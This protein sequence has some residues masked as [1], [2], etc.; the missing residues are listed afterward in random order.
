M[1]RSRARVFDMA[2]NDDDITAIGDLFE[3]TLNRRATIDKVTHRRHHDYIDGLIVA[4]ET[5]H[6]RKEAII[7]QVLGWSIVAA[8][9]AAVAAVAKYITF[10]PPGPGQ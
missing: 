3:T 1:A 10:G 4:G 2:L 7:R 5:R 8:M 6:A 9:A